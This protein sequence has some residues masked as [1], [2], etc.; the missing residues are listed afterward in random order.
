[1]TGANI[2]TKPLPSSARSSS[3]AA[4]VRF[5]S[6]RKGAANPQARLA[7]GGAL[8]EGKAAVGFHHR[9]HCARTHGRKTR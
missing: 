3:A 2:G 1:M 4:P 9:K 6:A 8:A 7:T 5:S